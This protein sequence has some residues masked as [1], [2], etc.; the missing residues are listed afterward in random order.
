MMRGE[1]QTQ[2]RQE[3]I[4]LQTCKLVLSVDLLNSTHCWVGSI[5]YGLIGLVG[6]QVSVLRSFPNSEYLSRVVRTT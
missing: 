2:I 3:K 1:K 6:V 4:K 5:N